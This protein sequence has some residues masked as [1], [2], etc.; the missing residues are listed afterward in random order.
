VGIKWRGRLAGVKE[1]QKLL[2]VAETLSARP[3]FISRAGF[4]PEAK[5]FAQREEIMISSK[6]EIKRLAE[7]IRRV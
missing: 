5:E 2:A 4:T 3:W 7:S 6:A 1:L